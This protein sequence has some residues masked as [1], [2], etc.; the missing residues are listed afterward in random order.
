LQTFE[1]P[2]K[3]APTEVSDLPHFLGCFF[4]EGNSAWTEAVVQAS[5]E[6]P[7]VFSTR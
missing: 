3:V 4:L 2:E 5:A 1:I 7:S 6:L